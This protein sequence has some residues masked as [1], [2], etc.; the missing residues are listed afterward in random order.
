MQVLDLTMQDA[1]FAAEVEKS[2]VERIPLG[3]EAL[4]K[5]VEEVGAMS[6]EIAAKVKAIYGQGG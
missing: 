1:E 4:Q 6:P 2:R 3:G 5:L